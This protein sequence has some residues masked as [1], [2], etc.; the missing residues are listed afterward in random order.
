MLTAVG[1]LLTVPFE[2]VVAELEAI[3]QPVLYVNGL[4]DAMIPA[5]NSYVTVQHLDNATLVLYSGAGHAFL[6]PY[7]KAFTKQV[8]DFLAA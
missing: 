7:A 8:A 2:Q 5:H 4:H 3:K 1:A 6:F